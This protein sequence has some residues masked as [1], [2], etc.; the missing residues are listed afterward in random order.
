LDLGSSLCGKGGRD[1]LIGGNKKKIR[2]NDVGLK[3]RSL[4]GIGGQK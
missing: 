4:E 2:I 1:G 3:S